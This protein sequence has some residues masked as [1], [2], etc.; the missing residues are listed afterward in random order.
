MIAEQMIDRRKIGGSTNSEKGRK[1]MNFN[2][3]LV[4]QWIKE[5]QSRRLAEANSH[6]AWSRVRKSLR[7]RNASRKVR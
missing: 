6:N 5:V 4:E 2:S 3:Y 7:N 1:M